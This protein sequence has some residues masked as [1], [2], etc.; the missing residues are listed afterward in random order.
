MRSYLRFFRSSFYFTIVG[1]M[2]GFAA[3]YLTEGSVAAG[4]TYL[5]L[6]AVLGV[7]ELSLSFDNAVV[8]ATVL[9]DMTPKWR[10]RF[11][12]WGMFIAV[13]GMRVIFPV[14]VVSLAGW[15]S[16]WS[17]LKMAV[18]NPHAYAQVMLAAHV[19]LAGFGGAFLLM[20]A[21]RFFFDSAKEEHW[22]GF[23]ERQLAYLGHIQ[24][25]EMAA[26]LAL[27]YGIAWLLPDPHEKLQFL[28]SGVLG[29][30][31]FILVQGIGSFLQVPKAGLASVERASA[32][33]FIYLEVLDASFSFD[34]VV[35]AFALTHN[36][37]IIAAGLGIGAM[38]VRSLTLLLVE[39]NT[40][41]HFIY[42]EHGAFY[43]IGLLAG[44]MMLDV[45]VDVPDA[46]MG[47]VG[48]GIIAASLVASVRQK[49]GTR[50]A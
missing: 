33:L 2:V 20:V 3:G 8:N 15:I 10:H 24:A 35:G 16:P 27:L 21:L 22:F 13:F 25:V 41:G 17:A 32:M 46:V 5:F 1:L 48:A 7:L 28:S 30:I 9:R 38:F 11:M 42:L 23:I 39:K 50:P 31:T 47:L 44:L 36:L 29:L 34:G 6:T 45:F 37:F 19:P 18:V 4:F 43:A 26:C 14:I 40:L 12:T 49:I